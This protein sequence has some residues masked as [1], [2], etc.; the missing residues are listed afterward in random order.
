[1]LLA[2]LLEAMAVKGVAAAAR[3]PRPARDARRVPRGADRLPAR[4]TRTSLSAGGARAD[5]P[6]PDA[7]VRRRRPR[8]PRGD[9]SARRSCSTGSPPTTPSTSRG[10]RAARRRRA[11]LRA[12]PDAG[13]RP[14][15]LHAHAVRVHE[16]RARRAVRRRRRR[17][18][19][20][21]VE[22]LGGQPTPG[23]RLGGRGRADP[24][25]RR[26]SSRSP[27]IRSTCSSRWLVVTPPAQPP[28]SSSPARRGGRASRRSSSSPGAR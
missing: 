17:P 24:A 11:A 25:G 19:R 22:Q 4:A 8:H 18:L 12:R 10:P 2:E 6:E 26:A 5:R 28:P 27:P 3:E 9:G 1:M 13:A 20:P 21:P 15:L 7:R 23:M 16:R 14:R